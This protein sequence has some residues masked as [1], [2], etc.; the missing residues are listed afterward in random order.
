MTR[1]RLPLPASSSTCTCI[2]CACMCIYCVIMVYW[3]GGL[4]LSTNHTAKAVSLEAVSFAAIYDWLVTGLYVLGNRD[5]D[6]N[7]LSC[8][9]HWLVL[10]LHAGKPQGRVLHR[11]M[12]I[13]PTEC[14]YPNPTSKSISQG[15]R[16]LLTY[17][18]RPATNPL[19]LSFFALAVDGAWQH[20]EGLGLRR[21][22]RRLG[23]VQLCWVGVTRI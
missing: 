12:C 9:L 20:I 3:G 21:T 18:P 2:L 4:P 11:C 15:L 1:R 5:A 17:Q 7:N 16:I 8:G 19:F 14:T 10:Y 6:A 13:P 22:L 23:A